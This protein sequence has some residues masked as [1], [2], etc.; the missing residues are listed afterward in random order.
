MSRQEKLLARFKSRPA[1]F[2]W[3]EMVRFLRGL[4][5]EQRN[6][7][8]SR[9]IFTGDGLPRIHLHEPHPQKIVKRRYLALICELL[10]NEGVI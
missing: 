9:R 1:D 6:G 7:N 3:D 2:T 10:E 5:Y 8:G 4:G